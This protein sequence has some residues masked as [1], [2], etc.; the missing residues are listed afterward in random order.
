MS[1]ENRR[2]ECLKNAVKKDISKE[3][4]KMFKTSCPERKNFLKEISKKCIQK[5]NIY[6]ARKS[7][8]RLHTEKLI[9]IFF[10]LIKSNCVYFNKN[11]KS[12]YLLKH[13][14][15]LISLDFIYYCIYEVVHCHSIA[16]Y[17]KYKCRICISLYTYVYI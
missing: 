2:S 12:A 3:E 11:P 10:N 14:K 9:H 4:K 1:K 7:K 6:M 5:E 8:S 15:L 17:I 16:C 13:S